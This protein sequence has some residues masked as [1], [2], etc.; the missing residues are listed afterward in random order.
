MSQNIISGK[1]TDISGNPVIGVSVT[2]SIPP[3]TAIKGYTF[4]NGNG[5]FQLYID[6][7]ADSI[8]I[9]FTHI[10][11]VSKSIRLANKTIKLDIRL[12]DG[13]HNLKPI[14][15]NTKPIY[16][17]KDTIN[18]SLSAFASKTDRVIGDVIK[19]LPGITMNGDQILYDGKP[20][21]NYYI[22]GLNLLE[23]NY[24][25]A[26]NNLP[27]DV[28]KKV[29]IVENDQPIKAFDSLIYSNQ[30]SLNI[31][32]KKFTSTGS[33]KV[34]IGYKPFLRDINLTP[35]TF[36][37]SMQMLNTFQSNNTGKNVASRLNT[38]TVSDV[39]MFF[40][41]YSIQNNPAFTGIPAENTPPFEEDRYLNNNINLLSSH[42]LKKLDN[43]IQLT[44]GLSYYNDFQKTNTAANTTTFAPDE[45]I[46]VTTSDS[47]T[48]N[49]N[50]LQGEF[51]FLKNEKRIY[52]KNKL[53][54]KK[55]WNSDFSN[56]V[57]NQ[58]T[59]ISQYGKNQYFNFENL[60]SG[61]FYMGKQLVGMNSR[62]YYSVSPQHL[63]VIPGQFINVLNNGSAY[64][65]LTQNVLYKDFITD[66]NIALIKSIKR[67]VINT[68][69]GVNVQQQSLESNIL[70]DGQINNSPNVPTN[71]DLSFLITKIY[72]APIIQYKIKALSFDFNLPLQIQ[73]FSIHNRLNSPNIVTPDK[74]TF[75]PDINIKYNISPVWQVTMNNRYSNSFADISQLYSAYLLQNYNILQRSISSTIG[76][77]KYR[78]NE[79]TLS[80]KNTLKCSFGNL[81]FQYSTIESNFLNGTQID[82]LGLT[83]TT[84]LPQQNTSKSFSVSCNYAIYLQPIKTIVK[85]ASSYTNNIS[86]YLLNESLGKIKNNTYET[87][88]SLNN[89]ILNAF[90]F[91]CQVDVVFMHN[92]FSVQEPDNIVFQTH[93]LNVDLYPI[94]NQTLSIN[95]EY[96]IDK[97]TTSNRQFFLNSKY[98]F[99]FNK[100]KIDLELACNN[101]L[102]TKQY[103]TIYNSLYSI[104]KSQYVLRPR[105]FLLSVRFNFK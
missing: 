2:Y 105:Q 77:S 78:T 16:E 92:K 23:G 60:F 9:K 10:N 99:S 73:N 74:L 95:S 32:L 54:F 14:I 91:S 101:L 33:G 24:P 17:N 30:A 98:V 4:S 65:Q 86:P 3:Y 75:Q 93:K 31:Q 13:S 15:I 42:L 28:V 67:I 44:G 82:S 76:N 47:S 102:N 83:S 27:V 53:S 51:V 97:Y 35:M 96:Y 22:N 68:K 89:T 7:D 104:S 39:D 94:K 48:H 90:D 103:R 50:H 11:Y 5:L 62:V 52:I 58:N 70:L 34:G 45:N 66:E 1:I 21:K 18:Y 26:N 61:A 38:F 63:S 20:L 41:E 57:R 69:A 46:I 49:I 25:L 8:L 19:K 56:N 87:S 64:A 81:R 79:L 59:T 71:N 6:K 55:R 12:T 100:N 43:G 72:V 29:Q 36:N 84:L 80:Y 88:L 40:N 85:L 37:K